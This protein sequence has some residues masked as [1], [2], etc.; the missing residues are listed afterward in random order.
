MF[1]LFRSAPDASGFTSKDKRNINK[2]LALV[3]EGIR[4]DAVDD[5]A[6]AEAFLVE[7]K[8]PID[9]AAAVYKALCPPVY[10]DEQV[11]A[12][13]EGMALITA[14]DKGGGNTIHDAHGL[15][16]DDVIKCVDQFYDRQ[17]YADIL[18]IDEEPATQLANAGNA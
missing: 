3:D 6:A 18:G 11:A 5:Y 8:W 12:A 17:Y 9:Y 7:I 13:R 1:N 16:T 14:G 4:N 15:S 10:T 2:F